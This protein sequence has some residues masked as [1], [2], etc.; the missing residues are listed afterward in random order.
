MGGPSAAPGSLA[1]HQAQ[2]NVRAGDGGAGCVSMRRE[3][4]VPKGGPDGGD[5]GSGGSIW[6]VAD[7]NVSSLLAFRDH[8]HRRAGSGTHGQG[9]KKHGHRGEDLIVPVPEGTV[10]SSPDGVLL[11]DLVRAGDRWQA[12][13]GGRGGKGNAWSWS[14]S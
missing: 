11:A 4:H 13:A 2:L 1:L 9:K 6:L 3:A 12:A 5:G 7:R 14:S 10:V 8:P